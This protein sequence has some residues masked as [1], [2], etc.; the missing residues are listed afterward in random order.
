M[1]CGIKSK[2]RNP[3]FHGQYCTGHLWSGN[4]FQVHGEFQ[5]K[6]TQNPKFALSSSPRM[7]NLKENDLQK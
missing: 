4:L 6:T 5:R 7:Q 2:F 3:G 1:K